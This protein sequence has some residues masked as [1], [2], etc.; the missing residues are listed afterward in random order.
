MRFITGVDDSDSNYDAE[1]LSVYLDGD[2]R[3]KSVSFG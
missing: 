3:V 2:L 1:R